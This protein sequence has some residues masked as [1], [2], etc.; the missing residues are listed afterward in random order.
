MPPGFLWGG[1]S[2]AESAEVRVPG[3]VS[4]SPSGQL[5]LNAHNLS[6]SQFLHLKNEIVRLEI[7]RIPFRSELLGVG[8]GALIY[9]TTVGLI[10]L[11]YYSARE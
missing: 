4:S 11:F 5:Q 3:P 7:F 8:R 6:G 2:Q 10:F 9:I 1:G